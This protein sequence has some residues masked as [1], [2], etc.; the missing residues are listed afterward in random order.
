MKT[1][2]IIRNNMPGI[3][4]EELMKKGATPVQ[5][6]GGVSFEDLQN[7]GATAYQPPQIPEEKGLWGR[8]ADRGKNI[9]NEFRPNQE[10]TTYQKVSDA[11]GGRMV[12]VAGNVVGAAG[13]VI[14][15][16]I[17]KAGKF[18]YNRLPEQGQENLKKGFSAVV[19]NPL[20]A[21]GITAL[22]GGI[23]KYDEFSQANPNA[24]KDINAL[25]NILSAIPVSKVAK[26]VVKE[27]LNLADDAL[28]ASQRIGGAERVGK[29]L[30]ASIDTGIEKGI[31]PTVVGKNNLA[32]MEKYKEKA[33]EAVKTVVRYKDKI[34][35]TDEFG[36]ATS[37]LPQ[38]LNQFSQAI[39]QT[40][41]AIYKKYDDLATKAGKAGASVE[42]NPIAKELSTLFKSPVLNDI[43]PEIV[44]Y[45][46]KRGTALVKRGQYTTKQAQEAIEQLN[47]SLESFYKNPS[48]GE[49]SR[50]QVDAL[51]VNNM[52]KSLDDVIEKSTEK[53]YQGLKN[54]YGS[55]KAIEKDVSKRA[56]VD[57]R[58]NAKGLIDFTDIFS[59]GDIIAGVATLNP[60]QI[61]KG[62]FQKM[63]ASLYKMKNDP[64]RIIRKMFEG[65]ER[66]LKKTEDL[67]TPFQPK[68]KTLNWSK[69][70]PVG[71]SLKDVSKSQPQGITPK[72]SAKEF[73]KQL[74]EKREAE[75]FRKSMAN[76]PSAKYEK[77]KDKLKEVRQYF[78]E[79]T[80]ER[81]ALDK[82]LNYL[83]KK[84]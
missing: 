40:K 37:K 33:R 41:K 72:I 73:Q 64:N 46:K 38:T 55:L 57:A 15:A 42:L 60:A 12:R 52:R 21:A 35:L 10:R 76:S 53:G 81:R 75:E 20:V 61:S 39:D 19:Q 2:I 66:S 74:I 47:K 3:S 68:S 79:T 23:E 17:E 30:D 9:I 6:T 31:R 8:L 18:A 26:P 70:K 49:F 63:I 51:I 50:L 78:K 65:A 58:K 36:E 24:A 80:P 71:L 83:D 29:A 67:K 27:G 84:K 43:A 32:Q 45:A 16:G 34:K 4:Y 7:Q 25:A 22:Q 14:G 62:V 5:P 13:D 82:I 56:I 11:L 44:Q 59:A 48:P 77:A 28:K 54:L 69:D 1:V